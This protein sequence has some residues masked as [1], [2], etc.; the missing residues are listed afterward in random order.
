[1]T[2]E[3][4]YR[5]YESLSESLPLDQ[6]AGLGG[7]LLYAGDI[8]TSRDLLYAANIAGA[9]SLGA[10]ADPLVLRQFMRD[11]VID[12]LVNSLDEALRILKNEVRKHLTVSVG[13]GIAP[14]LLAEQM[15]ERGVL[16]DLLPPDTK[17]LPVI[18][19]QQFLAQGSRR[20]LPIESPR[21]AFVTWNVDQHAARWLPRIDS[22][23][24][25][26]IPAQDFVRQRW[27]KLAPRYLGRLAQ[28]QR[29]IAFTE[30]EFA[31][32]QASVAATHAQADPDSAKAVQITIER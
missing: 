32:F 20:V 30:E 24:S 14:L 28:H 17:S 8:A 7:K 26:A 19:T 10:S 6:H 12:F 25:N 21:Q 31:N 1:M 23:A 29:G 4:V 27:L 22:L 5:M 3:P 2:A 13:V 15:L 16:P 9:A 18:L 11:G